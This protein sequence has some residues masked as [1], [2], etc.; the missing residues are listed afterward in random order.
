MGIDR[1]IIAVK[2]IKQGDIIANIGRAYRFENLPDDHEIY[3][4]LWR[5][6]RLYDSDFE[7]F[8]EGVG[9]WVEDVKR[10]GEFNL[11]EEI[12]DEYSDVEWEDR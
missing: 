6:I 9:E 12:C 2:D 11:L 3:I 8:I 4:E 7:Q 10:H 1:C 5:L